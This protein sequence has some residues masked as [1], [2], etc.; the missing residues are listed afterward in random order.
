MKTIIGEDQDSGED[1][2]K[3][4][5]GLGENQENTMRIL[6]DDFEN[7]CRRLQ[8]INQEKIWNREE[9]TRRREDQE[10]G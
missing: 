10:K 1:K 5:R 2:E 7:I 3:T 6:G 4:R 8:S 9:R